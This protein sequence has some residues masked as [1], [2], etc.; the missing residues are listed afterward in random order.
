MKKDVRPVDAAM[1]ENRV[2]K[3]AIRSLWLYEVKTM[4]KINNNQNVP[5]YLTL[6]GAEGHDIKMILDSGLISLTEIEAISEKDQHKIVAVES[7]MSAIAKLQK[8]FIGLKIKEVSFE[9]LI[10]GTHI[11]KWPNGDDEQLCRARV[12]NLDLNAPLKQIKLESGEVIFP[13]LNWIKKLC[14]IHSRPPCLDWTLCLTLHAEVMRSKPLD[15]WTRKFLCDNLQRD[16]KFFKDCEK[17]WGDDLFKKVISD[18][19]IDLADL[20]EEE[21]QKLLMV[22]VPKIIAKL[23]HDDGWL[24]KTEKNLRYGGGKPPAPMVTWIVKFTWSPSVTSTPDANY[25]NALQN[26]LSKTG[27]VEEDGNIKWN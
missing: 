4:A 21:Q 11:F 8:K 13:V 9:S 26:I 24:I 27:V 14:L 17:F 10:R 7:N 23:V 19:K 12:V 5:L 3:Q 20:E 6:S 16:Q 2:D 18:T 1:T 15:K 25:R 22:M